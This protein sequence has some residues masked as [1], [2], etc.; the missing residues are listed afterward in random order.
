[1]RFFSGTDCGHRD[2]E[3]KKKHL[4]C[5]SPVFSKCILAPQ[6]PTAACLSWCCELPA[7]ERGLCSCRVGLVSACDKGKS[8]QCVEKQ[9]KKKASLNIPQKDRVRQT[10]V[11]S[12]KTP[13]WSGP[14]YLLRCYY[15]M[16]TGL[17]DTQGVY[18]R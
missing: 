17:N 13:G 1:M 11:G 18:A 15:V 7:K 5:L 10:R 6:P 4:P 3:R 14:N 8:L 9:Q 2:C 16:A 12:A